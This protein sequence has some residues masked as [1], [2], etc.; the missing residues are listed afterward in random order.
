MPNFKKNLMRSGY[1]KLWR[2]QP[3]T[4][5]IVS[6]VAALVG[7]MAA[8]LLSAASTNALVILVGCPI[9]CLINLLWICI[10]DMGDGDES[11]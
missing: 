8:Q 5:V 1:L 11:I 10:N 7:V 4:T 2:T 9:A 3:L 6:V